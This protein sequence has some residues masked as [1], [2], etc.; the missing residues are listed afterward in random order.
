M[1]SGIPTGILPPKSP[2]QGT[3]ASLSPNGK[4]GGGQAPT[5]VTMETNPVSSEPAHSRWG[6]KIACIAREVDTCANTL[7]MEKLKQPR[8]LLQVSVHC[9]FWIT[10][11]TRGSERLASKIL[12]ANPYSRLILEEKDTLFG[13]YKTCRS[14]F[15]WVCHRELRMHPWIG[16]S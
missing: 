2:L 14:C 6:Y 13:S 8:L 4:K 5:Q 12:V 11:S 9:A 1:V 7:I 3:A 16:R 10:F 15:L